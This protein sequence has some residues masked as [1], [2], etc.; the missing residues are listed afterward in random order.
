MIVVLRQ[1]FV[2]DL[3]GCVPDD[4]KD[5]T[6]DEFDNRGFCLPTRLAVC[7]VDQKWWYFDCLHEKRA[8]HE[9][10]SYVIWTSLST[11]VGRS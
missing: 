1:V 11:R 5:G 8:G 7:D 9:D 2:F 3:R 10:F 4:P 6:S